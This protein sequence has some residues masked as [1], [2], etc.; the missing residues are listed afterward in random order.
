MKCFNW[1][2]CSRLLMIS[3]VVSLG[4]AKEQKKIEL[5]SATVTGKVSC[6]KEL[7]GG[8]V[9]FMHS[10]GALTSVKFGKDGAYSA[11]VTLGSNRVAVQ[12]QSSNGERD[13]LGR[14]VTVD[15]LPM[16]YSSFNT[17]NLQYEVKAGSNQFDI[18][19]TEDETIAT[20]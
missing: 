4:C 9:T 19:L 5:P 16:K 1:S 20:P 7:P 14:L 17:S 3:L 15:H 13:N 8:E 2:L 11:Q 6:S 18:A 12:S 10:S